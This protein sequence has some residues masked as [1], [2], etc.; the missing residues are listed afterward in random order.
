MKME[1]IKLA[2]SHC[3]HNVMETAAPTFSVVDGPQ[4]KELPLSAM[5][6]AKAFERGDKE[7][8]LANVLMRDEAQREN[9]SSVSVESATPYKLM[10]SS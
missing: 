2:N 4:G 9:H 3:D 1:E 10:Q 5:M 8:K 7:E 6:D